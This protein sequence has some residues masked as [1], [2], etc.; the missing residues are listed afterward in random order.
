MKRFLSLLLVA[1]MVCMAIPALGAAEEPVTLRIAWWGAQGRNDLTVEALEV[2][3]QKNPDIKVEVEY[4]NWDGYWSKLATQVA[5]GLTPDVIQMDYGYL[6]QYACNGV[7]A[8]LTPYV[9]SGA[10][11]TD[12]VAE[13][14]LSSGEVNGKI[15]AIS[16]GTNAL[17]VCYRTDVAEEAGIE[18][19]KELTLEQFYQ[20]GAEVYEKT[21]RTMNTLVGIIPLRQ[22]VRAYGYQLFN[23]AGDGLGFDDPKYIVRMWQDTL[24]AI[25]AGWALDI[26]E[27]TAD[28]DHFVLMNDS[29]AKTDWTNVVLSLEQDNDCKL[30]LICWPDPEDA[31]VPSTYFKPTMFWAVSDISNA[32]DAAVKFIDFFT[33]DPDCADITGS[34]RGMP[35]SSAIREHIMP[36]LDETAQK[37]AEHLNYLGQD[38]K[39]SAIMKADPAT[40]NEVNALFDQYQEAVL[41]R[42]VEDLTAWAQQF[43]DEA[44]ALLQKAAQAE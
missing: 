11:N 36:N 10:I 44:N 37:I 22:L 27:G 39:T 13:S 40:A 29:W 9:E 30:E 23:D 43:M 2:F 32:K 16:T 25:D 4:S 28:G 33:N 35:I 17:T 38:G 18:V 6:A 42:Q 19:P 20:M 1:V 24:D 21:G 12:N 34:D 26:G 5:G 31:T 15:Y 41:Y 8:D 3:Q 7:L 14:V